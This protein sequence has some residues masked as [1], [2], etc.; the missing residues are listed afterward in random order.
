MAVMALT[1]K[2]EYFAQLSDEAKIRYESKLTSAGLDIDPYCIE[3]S[4]W[5]REPKVI[6]KVM[7]TDISFYMVSTPSPYTKEAVKVSIRYS[8]LHAAAYS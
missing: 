5:T 6:P 7:W 2:S 3:E 1:K 4:L 8:N